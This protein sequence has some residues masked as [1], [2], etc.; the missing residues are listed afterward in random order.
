MFNESV[1][2]EIFRRGNNSE[3]NVCDRRISKVSF[4]RRCYSVSEA[5]SDVF[6][7]FLK[8]YLGVFY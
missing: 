6:V 5:W 8:Y 1:C 2:S 4:L 3:G 7:D